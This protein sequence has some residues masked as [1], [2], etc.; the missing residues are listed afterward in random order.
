MNPRKGL[1]VQSG[2]N[3]IES[4]A[5]M[6]GKCCLAHSVLISWHNKM[7]CLS[8]LAKLNI[9]VLVSYIVS[10]FSFISSCGKN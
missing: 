10:S 8:L 2:M 3:K 6:C 1:R 5:G 4:W 7:A 9:R